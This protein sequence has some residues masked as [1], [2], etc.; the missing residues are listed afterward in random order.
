MEKV[1]RNTRIWQV[2]STFWKEKIREETTYS[3]ER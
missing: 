1:T 3:A 2:L